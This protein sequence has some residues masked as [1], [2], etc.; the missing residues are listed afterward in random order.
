MRFASTKISPDIA[1]RG[2]R[3]RG[4]SSF[5]SSTPSVRWSRDRKNVAAS[6]RGRLLGGSAHSLRAA[7]AKPEPVCG[8]RGDDFQADGGL[9]DSNVSANQARFFQSSCFVAA[10][11]QFDI[12][13]ARLS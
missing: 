8:D 6:V 13:L 4:K 1:N 11:S 10:N 9:Y 2:R 7:G 12:V 5:H 3:K